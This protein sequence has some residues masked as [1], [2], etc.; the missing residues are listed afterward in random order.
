VIE[1]YPP[2]KPAIIIPKLPELRK[3]GDGCFLQL[4]GGVLVNPY[5]F[6]VSARYHRYF[7]TASHAGTTPEVVLAEIKLMID[8]VDQI[9]AMTAATTSGVTMSANAAH[10]SHPAWHAGDNNNTSYWDNNIIALP[11]WIKVDFGT[12]N[13]KA[14]NS[15]ALRAYD[16]AAQYYPVDMTYDISNDDSAWATRLL[17]TELSFTAGEEKTYPV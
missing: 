2:P 11:S 17:L 9:P 10:S 13:S 1:T 7:I 3:R 6:G 8:G 16:A 15:I 14:I 12:G 4:A 5:R